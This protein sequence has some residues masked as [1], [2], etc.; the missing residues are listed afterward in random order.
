[1]RE[2]EDSLLLLQVREGNRQAFDALYRKHWRYVYAAA[3][4]RLQNSDQAKDIAQDVFTQLWVL[5]AVNNSPSL[6]ENLT[7]YFY[8]AVRNNVLKWLEKERK[9]TPIPEL[10]SNLSKI[11][12]NADA[13]IIYQELQQSYTKVV[14]NMPAQQQQIFKMRYEEDIS[15]ANIASQLNITSKTVRNQLGRAL[16]K[17]KATLIFVSLVFLNS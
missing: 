3:Y 7:G 10:L 11:K 14:A 9:Y 6:I 15:S 5:L 4:K 17:L 8:I 16:T 12:D 13:E 1:M 2:T